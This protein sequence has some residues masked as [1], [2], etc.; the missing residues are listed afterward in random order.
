MRSLPSAVSAANGVIVSAKRNRFRLN[1]AL[2]LWWSM[3]HRVKPESMLF[4]DHALAET[5][6]RF[7]GAHH[8]V[9]E[10]SLSRI[11]AGGAD[12]DMKR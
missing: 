12:D 10:S 5:K 4:S 9:L 3:L 2:A 8:H 7:G 1:G 6:G 11:V